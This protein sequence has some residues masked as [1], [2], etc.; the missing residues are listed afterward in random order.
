VRPRAGGRPR[1]GEEPAAEPEK[2]TAARARV[3]PPS[4][5]EPH[6]SDVSGRSVASATL[7]AQA[8]N[9]GAPAPGLVGSRIAPESSAL[10]ERFRRIPFGHHGGR[11]QQVRAIA[12]RLGRLRRRAGGTI[13]RRGAG[14]RLGSLGRFGAGGGGI[15]IGG[16]GLGIG[17]V[18]IVLL[19]FGACQLLGGGGPIIADPGAIDVGLPGSAE[20]PADAPLDEGDLG[21]RTGEF[22]DAVQ[23]DVQLTWRDIFRRSGD[24]YRMASVVLY[25]DATQTGCGVGQAE[26]G[27]FYCPA[28]ERVYLDTS[29]FR[30]LDRRFGAPGDFAEAYVIAHELG[31]HVQNLL[32]IERQVRDASDAHPDEA[33]ELSVRLELQADCLA[34]VWAHS[35]DGRGILEPG[36][37][38]EGMRAAS[39][40]GDDRLQQQATGRIDRESFTHGT[41]EQRVGWL[42]NGFRVGNPDACDTFSP[43]YDDL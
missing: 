4:V 22:V 32:G 38:E 5:A 29:F 34:G 13:D 21:D 3:A 11:G 42:R 30:E 10:V 40:V 33:N 6:S 16:G 28:D 27:P 25:T 23:D 37:L 14:G 26:A 2:E 9:C 43:A 24:R 17:L 19:A 20:A 35:A 36:D 15:P 8:R 31:H 41:S 39:S 1:I 12:V 7:A 18:L